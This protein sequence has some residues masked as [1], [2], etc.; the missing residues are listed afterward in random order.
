MPGRVSVTPCASPGRNFVGQISKTQIPDKVCQLLALEN[1][2]FGQGND[3]FEASKTQISGQPLGRASRGLHTHTQDTSSSQLRQMA[4]DTPVKRTTHGGVRSGAGRPPGSR[5]R[6]KS[7]PTAVS[8]VSGSVYTHI[9]TSSST[10]EPTKTSTKRKPEVPSSRGIANFWY[11]R[12]PQGTHS[13]TAEDTTVCP[14]LAPDTPISAAKTVARLHIDTQTANPSEP[15]NE[16]VLDESVE[17]GG[18]DDVGAALLDD[19]IDRGDEDD[20]GNL[21]AEQQSTEAATDSANDQWLATTL[22]KVQK[23]I[24][25]KDQPRVYS[26][27][28]LW[29]YPKDPIFALQEAATTGVYA[30]DVLYLLPIFL[31]LPD[32]L[33][34]HPDRFHCECGEALN[35]HSYNTKPIARRVCTTSGSDYFLLTKRY[36]CPQREG[37]TRG[38]GRT[39]QGTDP[40]I[41]A[42]LPQFVQD[43]FPVAISHRSALDISQMDMMKITFAGRFGA[44][45]FSKMLYTMGGASKIPLFSSF[46]DRIGFA[47]YAP[48]T[49]YLK[50]MFI[51][52]FASHRIYIDRIMSSLSGRI[53][54]PDHTFKTIDHQGRLPGGEPIHTALYDGVNDAEEVRFY[55]LTLTQGFAPLQGMYERVQ[56][57]LARHGHRPTEAI[58]TDN[59]RLTSHE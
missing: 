20:E 16:R 23:Q 51:S 4:E 41:L 42:Q 21:D 17:D 30:P 19:E 26:Q 39:Y 37:N 24:K 11:T 34:G 5:N 57:E 40:W 18:D 33:P 58:Y 12:A 29:I 36:Y 10:A 7:K 45:P 31:W 43:R 46:K 59:P 6:P 8:A 53:L 1:P 13:M 44:D 25:I 38:C 2:N 9:A 22:E 14:D 55:A 56:V 32:Y 47:G 49:K 54:K 35:K 52:W 3:H 50:S 28:Q 27:G 15:V 48:S